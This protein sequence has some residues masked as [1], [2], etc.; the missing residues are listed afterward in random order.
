VP[1]PR[2]YPGWVLALL[3]YSVM[4]L[5]L[6]VALLALLVVLGMGRL[7]AIVLAALL[8]MMISY[9]LLRG[10]RD[11]VTR[12][13][14]A[15]VGSRAVA[16]AAASGDPEAAKPADVDAAHEDAV[17]DAA[18]RASGPAVRPGSEREADAQ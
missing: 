1:K 12:E 14:E 15:R 5:A 11:A 2:Y 7:W 10:Q 6:F 13:I 18:E 17:L 16:R 9:V 3:K 8:S 4:R